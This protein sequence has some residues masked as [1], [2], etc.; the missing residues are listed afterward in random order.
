MSNSGAKR[1]ITYLLQLS[2][3]SVPVVLTIVQTKQIRINIHKRNNTKNTVQSINN[4]KYNKYN[5]HITK[6][7]TVR[8][9]PKLNS[10]NIIKYPQYKVTLKYMVLLSPR[11]SP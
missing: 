9:T 8:D 11:S 6:T 2:F 7:P 4:T 3:H 5:T 1:L 10:H